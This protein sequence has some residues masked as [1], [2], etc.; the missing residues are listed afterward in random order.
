MFTNR[1][2]GAGQ[3]FRRFVNQWPST[4]QEVLTMVMLS[5]LGA[6]TLLLV[7]PLSP[8]LV[9]HHPLGCVLQVAGFNLMKRLWPW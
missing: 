2:F 3:V 1:P 4:S 9:S 7:V 5:V 6:F 8:L